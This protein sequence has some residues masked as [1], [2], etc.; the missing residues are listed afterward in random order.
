MSSLKRLNKLPSARAFSAAEKWTVRSTEVG[1]FISSQNGNLRREKLLRVYLRC[2]VLPCKDRFRKERDKYKV[3]LMNGSSFISP[4]IQR[5]VVL[6]VLRTVVAVGFWL[7][8]F[9][10]LKFWARILSQEIVRG[11]FSSICTSTFT[12]VLALHVKFDKLFVQWVLRSRLT[13]NLQI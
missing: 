5:K 7:L 4:R 9:L 10:Q 6:L 13:S 11:Q 2:Y 1:G 8:S 12:D 3:S